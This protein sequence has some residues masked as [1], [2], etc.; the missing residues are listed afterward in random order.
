M[1]ER[2]LLNQQIDYYRARAREYDEWFFRLGRYDRGPT[3][4]AEWMAEVAVVE[5]ALRETL[6]SGTVLELACGTGI[7]TQHLASS[8]RRVLAVD[9]S[10][11]VLAI[12]RARLKSD[13]IEYVTA[14]LF[15]WT[16]PPAQFDAVFFGFWLSHVPATRFEELWQRVRVALKRDGVAFFV[17]SLL[18]QT[19][20]ARD[21]GPIDTAGVARRRLNDGR[22]FE[23][24]KVFYEPKTLEQQLIQ[25]GW[26][27]WIR[28]SGKF[29]FYGAMTPTP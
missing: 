18:D 29:F 6:P 11:E 16:P 21:H 7:W 14:D 8:G 27:G 24:V 28:S 3:H 2:D 26:R 25:S 4:R 1:R 12:N 9:S 20:T 15:S 23:V 5:A 19:S 22:E 17:D 13:A 10:P